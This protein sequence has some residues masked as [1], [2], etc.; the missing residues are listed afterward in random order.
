MHIYKKPRVLNKTKKRTYKHKECVCVHVHACA[1][2]L[3]AYTCMH[4]FL[5]VCV[6]SCLGILRGYYRA[7]MPGTSSS[8]NLMTIVGG[9]LSGIWEDVYAPHPLHVLNPC[10]IE[11]P[12]LLYDVFVLGNVGAHVWDALEWQN[13]IKMLWITPRVHTPELQSLYCWPQRSRPQCLRKQPKVFTVTR[14][15]LKTIALPLPCLC[16]KG[17][18]LFLSPTDVGPGDL[19]WSTGHY[20]IWHKQWTQMYLW[21]HSSLHISTTMASTCPLIQGGGET[22]GADPHSTYGLSLDSQLTPGNISE[23]RL[24]M[25]EA[26]EIW[27]VLLNSIIVAVINCYSPASA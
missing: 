21:L 25:F 17:R 7:N 23:N 16:L 12:L 3:R 5:W 10:S 22:C 2:H 27:T 4:A 26:T 18:S 13:S 19:L 24:L 14:L 15:L 8:S 20:K 11:M 1:V 6:H 9:R